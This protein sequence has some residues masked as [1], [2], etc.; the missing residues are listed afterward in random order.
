MLRLP[1]LL[2][3][4]YR[5]ATTREVHSWSFGLVKAA[6]RPGAN[7]WEQRLGTLDDE[8]IFGPVRDLE[9][10]CGTY[11][12]PAH[13]G[14]ICDRC[15][16]KVATPEERRRRFGHIDLPVP[17]PHPWG[18]EAELVGT[19]PVL[20]AAFLESPAG[21]GLARSFE[22]LLEAAACGSRGELRAGLELLVDGLLPAVVFAHEW[23]LVESPVLAR[24]LVLEGRGEPAEP[25]AAPD[26]GGIS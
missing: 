12:G 8:R 1:P 17:L 24:G 18:D 13:R 11:R 10:T 2:A 19:V 7:G 3:A 15:G 14:M 23:G 25:G 20:P 16:V 26:R 6:R 9:C 22:G 4:N 5:L 21:V